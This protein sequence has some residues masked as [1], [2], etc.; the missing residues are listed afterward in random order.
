[1][2]TD[3]HLKIDGIE[4][5]SLDDKHKNEI[6]IDSFSWGVSNM[7]ATGRG[8]GGGTGK[9]DFS[10]INFTKQADKSS[11]KLVKAAAS[12]DHIVKAV[13][14]CRKASGKGGQVEYLKVTLEDV[15]VSNYQTGG[16]AG[17]SSIPMDQFSLNFAKV[18]YEYMPQK[19]D[20]TLEG[21]VSA[22]YDRSSN[23]AS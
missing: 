19:A 18:K 17:A 13:L 14:S 11:P 2:A 1:M 20:G 4:G 3:Y 23:K 6:E 10:D 21:A 5:E 7:G 12:G 16:S 9:A 22:G 15:M 8:G